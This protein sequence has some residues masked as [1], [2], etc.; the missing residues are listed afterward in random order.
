MTNHYETLGL[1]STAS[2]QEIEDSYQKLSKKFHPDNNGGDQYFSDLYGNIKEAYEILSDKNKKAEY[3][4]R[5][6]TKKTEPVEKK[7]KSGAPEILLFESDKKTFIE[8]DTIELKWETRNADKVFIKPFG[9]LKA[10][11][12]KIFKLKNF[13]KAELPI[14]LDAFNSISDKTIS[15]T[16]I[17]K[18]EIAEVDF[19]KFEEEGP[20]E[21][22]KTEESEQLQ[23]EKESIHS[24][25]FAGTAAVESDDASVAISEESFF[26]T[27]G[28]LRRSSYLGRAILLGIPAG[29]ASV[30]IQ[31]TYDDTAIGWCAIVMIICSVL[32]FIQFI[33]RLHDINLSGWYSLINLIPYVGGFFGLIVLFIDGSKG[34]NKYGTDPKNRS[35]YS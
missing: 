18:N 19:S 10:N 31:D 29:I 16:V 17:L 22:Y 34:P 27:S 9:E 33:K 11:G 20:V 23:I 5:E 8:G 15:R 25:S 7:P 26:S 13:N 3:D 21:D 14:R 35:Q 28:R 32:I 2:Q 24:N 1:K 4:N 6:H 12:S 30:I